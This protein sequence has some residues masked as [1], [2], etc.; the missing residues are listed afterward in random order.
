MRHCDMK[1]FLSFLILWEVSKKPLN[2]IQLSKAL[3][4]RR[5]HKPSPGTIY[6]ALKELKEAKLILAD[7]NKT[8][9]LTEK[10]KL[11]LHHSCKSFC[12]IFYDTNEIKKTGN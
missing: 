3:E 5:G 6:P 4:K 12:C 2:G 7:K 8:Y 9:S 10:G 11:E 1:G